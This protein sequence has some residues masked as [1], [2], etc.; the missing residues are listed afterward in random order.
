MPPKKNRRIPPPPKKLG[1]MRCHLD[2]FISLP[3][4]VESL[5]NGH[6]LKVYIDREK[7]TTNAA[8]HLANIYKIIICHNQVEPIVKKFKI[9]SNCPN[10]KNKDLFYVFCDETFTK[11]KKLTTTPSQSDIGPSRSSSTSDPVPSSSTS[12]PVPSST[13]DTVSS[14]LTSDPVSLCGT[15]N[16][17]EPLPFQYPLRIPHST[18]ELELKR[19]LN[20]VSKMRMTENIRYKDRMK[21]LKK[22]VDF[23]KLHKIK[24][25]MQ[26]LKRKSNYMAKKD[27][28]IRLLKNQVSDLKLKLKNSMRNEILESKYKKLQHAHSKMLW[29]KKMEG[30]LVAKDLY[31]KLKAD[32]TTSTQKI[33]ELENEVC[34]LQERLEIENNAAPK[35]M[36]VKKD[37][38]TFST[39]MRMLVY[40]SIIKRV[41]TKNIPNLI[42]SHATIHGHVPSSLPSRSTVEQMARELNC[43]ADLKSAN[44]ILKNRNITL[45]FDSTTQ[46]GVHIN[47]VHVTTASECDVLAANELPGGTAEDYHYHIT[48]TIDNLA[49]VYTDFHK[50]DYQSCRKNM[51]DNITNTMTDR[52]AVNHATIEKVRVLGQRFK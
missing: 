13:S 25:L 11:F 26:D 29:R 18:L 39:N 50:G 46:G 37:N 45:G 3:D 15:L 38:K 44:F 36:E 17:P 4:S 28:Q 32:F 24:S 19:R 23:V 30:V 7:S 43:I 35:G 49:A 5:K 10:E 33:R 47:S 2:E 12:D 31:M 51:I 52:A 1:V 6:V 48:S 9:F 42:Q 21:E 8:R 40:D 22:K 41:P 27:Q 14:F 34:Q 20:N 16:M